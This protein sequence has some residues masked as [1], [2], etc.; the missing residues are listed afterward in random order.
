MVL[1]SPLTTPWGGAFVLI[2]S[3]VRVIWLSCGDRVP[4][5]VACRF[6][7]GA[8]VDVLVRVMQGAVEGESLQPLMLPSASLAWTWKQYFAPVRLST[9]ACARVSTTPYSL[10][11]YGKV[12]VTA[13]PGEPNGQYLMTFEATPALEG[14]V[15][16]LTRIPRQ[17]PGT[18]TMFV[19]VGGGVMS[20]SLMP[21][22]P[23]FSGLT[24]DDRSNF[25]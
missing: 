1:G 17:W 22:L 10:C 7:A 14:G 24:S 19:G 12:R 3:Q 4:L 2:R 11:G 20:T 9:K 15:S 8:G 6:A 25:R 13:D 18:R 16:H 23:R 5:P 21:L